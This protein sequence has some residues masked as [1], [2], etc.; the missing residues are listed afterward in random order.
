MSKLNWAIRVKI[1]IG[2]EMSLACGPSEEGSDE[3]MGKPSLANWLGFQQV[4]GGSGTNLD[5]IA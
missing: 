5:I 3:L 1:A 2:G 4:G